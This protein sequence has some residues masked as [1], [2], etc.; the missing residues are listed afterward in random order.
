MY[1]EVSHGTPTL[2]ALQLSITEF[3]QIPADITAAYYPSKTNT[4]AVQRTC[5][6]ICCN[7]L[8]AIVS[9]ATI[10]SERSPQGHETIR[11]SNKRMARQSTQLTVA[12]A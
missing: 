10:A 3:F 2:N 6:S 11:A 4:T 9:C 12:L 1:D 5:K 8:G 7:T